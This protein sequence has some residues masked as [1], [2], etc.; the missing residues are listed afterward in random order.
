M[1]K[2]QKKWIPIFLA[3]IIFLLVVISTPLSTQAAD[4]VTYYP[5]YPQGTI[6]INQPEIG[7]TIFLGDNQLE[8]VEFTLNG[9]AIPVTYDEERHTFYAKPSK[10]LTGSNTVK[11]TIHLKGWANTIEKTWTFTVSKASLSSLPLPNQ[12]QLSAINLANDY[13]YILGIPL[14]EWDRSLNMAA[15]KHAEYQDRLNVFGH[16]QKEGTS[17]F[18]GETVADRAS[19]Y[20]FYGDTSEDISYQSNPSIQEAID[21][22][23]D[24]PYHR[25]PFL[26]PSYQYYGYGKAGYFHVINFGG[27]IKSSLTWVAYP[28]QN[29]KDVPIA[30]NNYETPNPLRFYSNAPKKVGYPI[31]IGVYGSQ[32]ENV[33][34]K[35][36]IILDEEN[37]EVP[38]YVN[39]PK[40]TGGNDEHLQ[41]EVILIPKS[42][43][44]LDKKYKVSV[45]LEVK[46]N[47]L[48]KSYDQTWTFQTEKIAGK[49]KDTLHQQVNYPP[50]SDQMEEIHFRLGERF[51]QVDNAQY[52][53]DAIPYVQNNRTMVPFKVLGNSL[54]AKVDWNEQTKT[55]FY[56]KG[57]LT[58]ELPINTLQVKVNGKTLLLDQGAITKDG[59]SYVPIRFISEQLGAYVDWDDEKQQVT[60]KP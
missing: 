26:N 5:P 60:I 52:P 24:A 54:G 19:Y 41:N 4:Q 57:N 15:Q 9:A 50:F 43:L 34:L 8:K 42:P 1:M 31:M 36:A 17:G 46:Q 32:V 33:R 39:S 7:W 58:I 38:I 11:A 20:G 51:V 49:G 28:G 40:N 37:H 25:I 2:K 23:F 56:Q 6:G 12:E 55:V 13:R 29:Q 14:Y 53:I 22:L 10:P 30:W 59:R 21:G 44:A 45:I 48:V 35:S 27:Q 16:Y 47:Q 18:F 3:Q